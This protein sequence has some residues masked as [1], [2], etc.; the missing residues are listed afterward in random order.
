LGLRHDR[1]AI[2]VC[3][4]EPVNNGGKSTRRVILDRLLVWH[5]SRGREV[6]LA[7]VEDAI[8]HVSQQYNRALDRPRPIE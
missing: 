7:D 5:G 2:A 8:I 1:T 6:R 3:H 4:A